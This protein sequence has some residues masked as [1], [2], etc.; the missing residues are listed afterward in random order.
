MQ[1]PYDEDCSLRCLHSKSGLV[2]MMLRGFTFGIIFLNCFKGSRKWTRLCVSLVGFLCVSV[3]VCVRACVSAC[4]RACECEGRCGIPVQKREKGVF[5]PTGCV[6]SGAVC[7]ADGGD[8]RVR[9]RVRRQV[10][11]LSPVHSPQSR[12]G[13]L[14]RCSGHS[15]VAVVMVVEGGG[16]LRT[17]AA[18]EMGTSLSLKKRHISCFI[19]FKYIGMLDRLDYFGLACAL[20]GAVVA[21]RA[22]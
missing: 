7:A 16:G 11:A 21:V 5:H 1:F 6:R 20:H 14:S 13:F 2:S 18:G 19:Q 9:V 15:E 4:V 10:A 17:A 22:W 12:C 3:G 8:V